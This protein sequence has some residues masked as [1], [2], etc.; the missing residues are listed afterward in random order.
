VKR[1]GHIGLDLE[2]STLGELRQALVALEQ[3]PDD[4]TVRVRTRFGATAQ[5]ALVRRL[6]AEYGAAAT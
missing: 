1:T 4:A 6:T 2:T 3:L 5:G